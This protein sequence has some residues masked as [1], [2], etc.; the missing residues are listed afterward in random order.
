[1][2]ALTK[3]FSLLV[4][5]LGLSMLLL[6]AGLV[7]LRFRRQRAG[8]FTVLAGVGVLWVFS[9]PVVADRLVRQLEAGW[10]EVPVEALPV[11]DAVVVLGGAFSWGNGEWT[12]PDAGGNVDRYWHAARVFHAGKAGL[13]ILSGGRAPQ[14][15]GGAT[16][17]EAGAVFLADMDVPCS[18]MILDNEAMTTRE[19]AVYVAEIIEARGL[20]SLHVVTSAS[21]MR[22]SLAALGGVDAELIPVATDFAVADN[23]GFTIRRFL[24]SASG[25]SRSTR[26]VHELIGY[27]Y[28][29]I[30][31]WA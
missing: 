22:R 21:H 26:A 13:V 27:W 6:L 19:N 31:G 18:A 20:E 15:T 4:Y 2:Y 24:P 11:A 30:R 3:F 7:L 16:E 23:P 12:Y 10:S 28:Y 17:A 5:P 29:R 1:M 14:R 9:M 25:L 8:V